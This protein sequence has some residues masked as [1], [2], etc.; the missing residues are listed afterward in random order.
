MCMQVFRKQLF[1]NGRKR[2]NKLLF[3]AG[4]CGRILR[5]SHQKQNGPARGSLWMDSGRE[6]LAVALS[7]RSMQEDAYVLR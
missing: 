1:P 2:K 3:N 5:V 4:T 6:H 7:G